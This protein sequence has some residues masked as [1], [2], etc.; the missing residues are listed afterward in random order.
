[1]VWLVTQETYV[2]D[3]GINNLRGCFNRISIETTK[4]RQGNDLIKGGN[5]PTFNGYTHAYNRFTCSI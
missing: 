2:Q 1:M 5:P 3:Y 4:K